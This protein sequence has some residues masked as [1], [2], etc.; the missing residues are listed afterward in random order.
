LTPWGNLFPYS[1]QMKTTERITRLN[2]D[3]FLYEITTEDP[4][5]LTHSF[6]V[7][8]PMRNDPSY[9]MPEYACLEGDEIVHDYVTTNRYERAH[10]EAEPAQ[11]PVE[12]APSVADA[13]AGTWVGSL[14]HM[15]TVDEQ[16]KLQFTKNANGTVN[17]KLI[18]TNFGKVDKPLRQFKMDGKKI[19]FSTPQDQPWSFSGELMDDGT[20]R[21]SFTSI[22]IRPD[23]L[24][25][26]LKRVSGDSSN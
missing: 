26:T 23:A 6:T 1:E 13:L 22:E 5:I 11:K 20:I 17:A 18:G 7:R 25:V 4:V 14:E 12:V 19:R 15:I 8:Y 2:D 10:P 3:W 9:I 21:G 24:P 16:V